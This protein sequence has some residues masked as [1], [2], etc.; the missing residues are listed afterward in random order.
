[1]PAA[2][3]T[4]P[5]DPDPQLRARWIG[6]PAEMGDA[7]EALLASLKRG[8]PDRPTDLRGV[9]LR[10]ADLRGVDLSGC[11][12]TGADLSRADLR[13]AT[14]I[15]ADLSSA[16]LCEARLDGAELAGATLLGASL[17]GARASRAGFGRADLRRAR[18]FGA[19]LDEASFVE[20]RLRRAD[21]RTA[22][23]KGARFTDA[24][25]SYGAFDRAD[26]ERAELSGADVHRASFLEA[27]LRRARLRSLR[28]FE[29]ASFLRADVRDVDFS[30]AYLLRRRVLDENFLHE[31]EHRS[32]L[33][34]VVFWVWWASSDCG[35]SLTRWSAW[36]VV[37]AVGFAWAFSR[38]AVDFGEHETALSP[39]YYSV[40]TLT[41]LGYGDAV[42]VSATAQGLAMAEVTLGYVMLGGLISIFA[43][44]LARRGE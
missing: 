9:R 21:A 22:S 39:L 2:P 18:L 23:A 29:R 38:A 37:I 13:E 41:T 25:L 4:L 14:L 3:S 11:D 6:P 24:D 44:K 33:H 12:L 40:V 10:G 34:R 17:E 16:E 30:G 8:G 36:T 28:R 1:M 7:R 15:G 31:F 27:D 43:N 5:P 20:A 32:R 26:L 42:P 19:T 35:R